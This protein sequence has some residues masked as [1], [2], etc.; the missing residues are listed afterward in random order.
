MSADDHDWE[1]LFAESEADYLDAL[2]IYICFLTTYLRN[3]WTI[4]NNDEREEAENQLMDS[5]VLTQTLHFHLLQR[6][7]L[8]DSN[9]QR[10][11]DFFNAQNLAGSLQELKKAVEK[12][13]FTSQYTKSRCQQFL[14]QMTLYHPSIKIIQ[15][16]TDILPPW[17][18]V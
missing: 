4:D 13:T 7:M 1:S 5:L 9:F 14:K 15:K 18:S 11:D 16:D 3:L 10:G 17:K 2:S 6:K 12:H 8:L